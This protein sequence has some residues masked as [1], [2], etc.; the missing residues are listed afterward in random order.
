MRGRI[1]IYLNYVNKNPRSS[2][3]KSLDILGI[4]SYNILTEINK[5]R[6]EGYKTSKFKKQ[7]EEP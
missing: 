5:N 6:Q 1:T 7:K 4:L 2:A 3:V